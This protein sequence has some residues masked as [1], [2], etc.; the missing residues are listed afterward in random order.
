MDEQQ[1][2]VGQSII[3]TRAGAF[4]LQ[5]QVAD[6]RLKVH[7]LRAQASQLAATANQLDAAADVAE[8]QALQLLDQADT[9]ESMVWVDTDMESE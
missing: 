4:D 5:K 1:D 8:M 9:M 6:S 3:R 7:G 2:A